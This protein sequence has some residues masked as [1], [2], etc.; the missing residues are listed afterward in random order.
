MALFANFSADREA[1]AAEVMDK[2]DEYMKAVIIKAIAPYGFKRFHRLY[3]EGT[4]SRNTDMRIACVR[5]LGFLADPADEHTLLTAAKD[6]EWV[7]RS[8]AVKGLQK[9]GTPA[10]IQGV[11]EATKDKEWWVRQAAAY[12]LI[13]MNVNISEIEDVLGGY[14][15]YASDA[16][17]YALYR[18]VNLKED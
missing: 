2:C 1:L 6:R 10:A 16:V 13:D 11:K 17:K 15:K 8:A 5:A 9:L 18:S 4:A 3:S 14:D 12:S 7:V